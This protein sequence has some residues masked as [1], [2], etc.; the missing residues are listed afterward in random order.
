MHTC[1]ASQPARTSLRYRA[2]VSEVQ[3]HPQ[4]CSKL[5]ASLGYVT[6][7]FK[8][9]QQN[10]EKERKKISIYYN[11]SLLLMDIS[12]YPLLFITSLN[13]SFKKICMF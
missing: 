13:T 7:C 8:T 9:E 2:V 5:E 12:V 1:N 3:G 10:K 6:P 11:I 4:P